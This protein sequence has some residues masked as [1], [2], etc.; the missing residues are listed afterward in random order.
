MMKNYRAV[1]TFINWLDYGEYAFPGGY[2]MFMVAEDGSVICYDCSKDEK[3]AIASSILNH[4][5]DGWRIVGRDINYEN[6]D[7]YCDNCGDK[8]KSSY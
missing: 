7:L 1:K 8:I 4:I 3:R 6:P 2:Q 5:N